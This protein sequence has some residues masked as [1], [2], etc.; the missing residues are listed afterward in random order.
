MRT[1]PHRYR[2]PSASGQ[3][4]HVVDL[5]LDFCSCPDYQVRKASYGRDNIEA[6]KHLFAAGIK[7]AKRRKVGVP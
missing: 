1:G 5:V 4:F 3:G 7:A 2:V 6:C